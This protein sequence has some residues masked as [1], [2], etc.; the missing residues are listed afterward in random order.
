MGFFLYSFTVFEIHNN[1]TSYPDI[2]NIN[3]YNI[4]IPLRILNTDVIKT[5][6]TGVSTIKLFFKLK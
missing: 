1:I 2:I 3:V 6:E 4:C 5:V